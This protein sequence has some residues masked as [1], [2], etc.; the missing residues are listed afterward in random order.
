MVENIANEFHA[1]FKV[2]H[3]LMSN[4]VREILLVSSSYDAFIIEEDGSLASRI[5]NEYSGLNL[6]QPPRVT[7]TSSVSKALSLLKEKQFD[8]VITMPHLD[9]MDISP[10]PGATGNLL[11]SENYRIQRNLVC[12]RFTQGI[13]ESQG[14]TESYGLLTESGA[15]E[16][17]DFDVE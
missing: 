9:E 10:Y 5:I 15:M 6:S 4:K 13:P 1:D 3:E 7:R 11:L 16:Q 2:F 14:F 8:L 12:A 17:N